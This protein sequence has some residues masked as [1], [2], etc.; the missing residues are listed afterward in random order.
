LSLDTYFRFLHLL[1]LNFSIQNVNSLNVSKPGKIQFKKIC[2]VT[3]G[4]CDI[5]ILCDIR[6]N[7]AFKQHGA[8]NIEKIFFNRGYKI[9][10][11]S[12]KNSRGVGI[13]ISRKVNLVINQTLSDNDDNY[14]LLDITCG[15]N[16]L[17]V[18]TIYGQ[19][20]NEPAFFDNLERDLDII[21]NHG[22]TP[23][24]LGGDWNATWDMRDSRHNID[25]INMA[26]IPSKFRT[27]KIKHM[28]EVMNLT[29]PYRYFKPTSREYK[30]IPNARE[31][32][33]RSRIDY[34]LILESL[35]DIV[36]SCEIESA[37]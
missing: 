15:S 27:G 20:T 14:L 32:I 17:I 30:Y 24:I 22:Q 35:V 31:N 23:S 25:V 9:I 5:I 8:H 4:D 1:N 12:K 10:Y 29:E 3:N 7:S 26:A 13:L 28:A 6:L 21:S 37:P 11:N 33:N 18:G 19:N 34:F 36:K 16:N 2:A